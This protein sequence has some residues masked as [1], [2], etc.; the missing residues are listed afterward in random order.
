MQAEAMESVTRRGA[1]LEERKGGAG[2]Q[3]KA[4]EVGAAEREEEGV[5]TRSMPTNSISTGDRRWE[6]WKDKP[7]GPGSEDRKRSLT[8]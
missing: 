5:V 3:G 6:S 8:S 1:E 4:G 7:V 2:E